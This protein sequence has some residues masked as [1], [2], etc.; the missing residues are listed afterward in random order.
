MDIQVSVTKDDQSQHINVAFYKHVDDSTMLVYNPVQSTNGI[1]WE[2]V[3]VIMGATVIPTFMI[4]AFFTRTGV[5]QEMVDQ[6]AKNTGIVASNLKGSQSAFEAQGNH[7][8]DMRKLLFDADYIEMQSGQKPV[9]K[10]TKE[11]V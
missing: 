11:R 4:P 6:F 1:K 5:V 3:E 8:S 7:L 2:W 10:G 9:P